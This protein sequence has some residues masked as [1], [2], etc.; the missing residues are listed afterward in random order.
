MLYCGSDAHACEY[1]RKRAG[2]QSEICGKSDKFLL[3]M[4]K[5]HQVVGSFSFA[6]LVLCMAIIPSAIAAG[7]NFTEHQVGSSTYDQVRAIEA[8]D[9]DEDG[10]V[11]IVAVSD[12]NNDLSWYDNN[13]NESFTKRTIDAS[14][15]GIYD[16]KVIDIDL[17][18][19]RDIVVSTANTPRT[20]WYSNNGS[21]T[22]TKNTIRSKCSKEFHCR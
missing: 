6:S 22:F 13:G 1:V 11:D 20:F 2:M 9:V 21:E 14:V 12:V 3:K 18:G 17:D 10:D 5:I 4:G 15:D 16:L 19:D 7:I 8:I